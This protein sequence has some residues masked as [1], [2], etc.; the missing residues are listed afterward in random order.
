MKNMFFAAAAVAAL[1]LSAQPE[2]IA[3]VKV[4]D[5]ATFSAAVM[6]VAE[7]SGNAMA[8][9][10]LSGTLQNAAHLRFFGTLR[11]SE[12]TTCLMFAEGGAL[13]SADEV[14]A[15]LVCPVAVS[16]ADFKK[17]H[18][19]STEKNGVVKV[20]KGP[21][22]EI[23]DGTAYVVFSKDGK[24]AAAAKNEKIARAALAESKFNEKPIGSDIARL[25]IMPA[26]VKRLAQAVA[27]SKNDGDIRSSADAKA[28]AERIKNGISAGYAAVSIGDKGIDLNV[29]LLPVK[30][31]DYA[32]LASKAA[33]DVSG[34]LSRIPASAFAG[35]AFAAGMYDNGKLCA[36]VGEIKKTLE[37]NGVKMDA[38]NVK[39]A[40][41]MLAAGFDV[42]SFVKYMSD[43]GKAAFDKIDFAAM[44]RQ[45]ADVSAKYRET[46]GG[47][48]DPSAKAGSS[49]ISLPPFK[50]KRTVGELYGRVLPEFKSRRVLYAGVFSAY[51]AMKNIM[52][53]I[54]KTSGRKD[55]QSAMIA[56]FMQMMPPAGDGGTALAVWTEKGKVRYLMRVSPGEIKGFSSFLNLAAASAMSQASQGF[57]QPQMLEIDGDDD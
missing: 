54:V 46:A 21:A 28:L 17:K 35:S 47:K 52:E 20:T 45:L 51:D 7:F 2:K 10:M 48:F 4:A 23:F 53:E 56:Q 38:L 9:A 44:Q 26:G 31:S 40:G 37:K 50:P 25:Y 55:A 29:S 11:N 15:A 57:A 34:A 5:N 19:G 43:G 30:G 22:V 16:K 12:P 32:S 42:R 27:E 14:Q 3:A 8:G 33:I 6:K 24:W 41:D 18:P 13:A 36:Y 1:N 39:V 49:C